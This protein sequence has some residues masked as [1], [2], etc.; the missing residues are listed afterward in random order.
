MIFAPKSRKELVG[1][2]VV[3][4]KGAHGRVFEVGVRPNKLYEYKR[5]PGLALAEVLHTECVFSDI[6]RGEVARAAEVRAEFGVTGEGA[7]RAILAGGTARRDSAARAV[8]LASLRKAVCAGLQERLRLPTGGRINA[9]Q[10]EGL[11]KEVGH[12]VST[13]PPKVQVAEIAKKA[14]QLGWQRRRIKLRASESIDWAG[15]VAAVP[16][17]SVF[18]SHGCCLE[19]SDD[20]YGLICREAER[21]GVSIEEI[22]EEEIEELVEI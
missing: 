1:V 20:L 8:E 18:Q 3:Q 7:L 13:K 21:A 11:L 5:N 17:G 15:V 10:A 6:N 16:E 2:T 9:V 22:P 14:V 4:Y 12:A 19:A